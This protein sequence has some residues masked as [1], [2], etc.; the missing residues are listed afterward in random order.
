MDKKLDELKEKYMNIPIPKELDEVVNKAL[1]RKEKRTVRK[2]WIIA[3]AAAVIL[4]ISSINAN[5]SFAQTME[6]VPIVGNL[7]KLLTFVEYKVEEENFHANIKVPEIRNL[8]NQSLQSALNEKYLKENKQLYK[9]FMDEMDK[10]KEKNEGNIGVDSDYEVI[11]ENEQ[12]LTIRRTVVKTAASAEQTVQ[13]DTVDKKNEVLITLPSLFKNNDYV[14]VISENIKEQM[15]NQMK[16]DQ[17]KIYWVEGTGS[18]IMDDEAFK[19]ISKDQNFYINKKG[20]LVISFNE[21]DVAP[22]YMGVVEFE[23]PTKIIEDQLVS[24]EYVK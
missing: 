10:L 6:K 1:L 3:I 16:K 4:F 15:R 7:I 20:K 13:Y 17:N 5:P 24:N 18:E 2:S 8:E 21:Y 14:K 11:E 12:I 19:I 22:G 23:I 9:S